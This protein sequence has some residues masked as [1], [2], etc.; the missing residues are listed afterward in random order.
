MA[1]NIKNVEVERLAAEVAALQGCSKTEAIRV[2][3]CERRARLACV[4]RSRGEQIRSA[5][6]TTIWPACSTGAASAGEWS[7]AREDALLGFGADGV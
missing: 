2:A 6:A 1:L 7:K 5:L 3:L 4:P